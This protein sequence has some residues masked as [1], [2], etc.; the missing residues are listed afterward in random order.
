MNLM[1]LV[2][3]LALKLFLKSN[4]GGKYLVFRLD[5]GNRHPAFTTHLTTCSLLVADAEDDGSL[6]IIPFSDSVDSGG[7]PR[8]VTHQVFSEKSEDIS[9]IAGAQKGDNSIEQQPGSEQQVLDGDRN[10]KLKVSA[11]CICNAPDYSKP[12]TL[13]SNALFVIPGYIFIA[14]VRIIHLSVVSALH[15]LFLKLRRVAFEIGYFAFNVAN[16]CT[17]NAGRVALRPPKTLPENVKRA[18]LVQKKSHSAEK[19]EERTL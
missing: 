11:S 15:S 5:K 17:K 4:S 10:K 6:V 1:D 7:L 14:F 13:T 3:F 2:E 12:I 16:E 19:P 18:K 8:E 9:A